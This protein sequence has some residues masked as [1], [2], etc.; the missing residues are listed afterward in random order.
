VSGI[1]GS[2]AEDDEGGDRF[3]DIVRTNLYGTY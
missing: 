2:N 1:G 3:D